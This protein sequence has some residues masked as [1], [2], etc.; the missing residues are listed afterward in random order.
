M[1]SKPLH[2]LAE[3]YTLKTFTPKGKSDQQ[4]KEE[5]DLIN[6]RRFEYDTNQKLQNL[7]QELVSLSLMH[8]RLMSKGEG[9]RKLLLIEFENL[10]RF[11]HDCLH[12]MDQR[13]GDI[14]T[15]L[16]EIRDLFS[17]FKDE[18]EADYLTR[19]DFVTRLTPEARK[20]DLLEKDLINK[21]EFIN[22]AIYQLKIHVKDQVDSVKNELTPVKPD[23]D[24]VDQ[25]L[26]ERFK[27]FKIDFDGLIKEIAL[28]KK[29]V[30]YDQKK[31]ENVY[32]LIERLKEGKVC[33]KKE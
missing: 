27:I 24:P 33:H 10:Q 14:E 19:E 20:I 2:L 29:A 22:L 6:A 13:I 3:P 5:Q 21:H 25:K 17:D 32:T 7:S 8:D 26:D 1:L 28:L 9:D 23:A 11:V 30:A 18:I 15:K 31:F 16:C 4:I 12:K